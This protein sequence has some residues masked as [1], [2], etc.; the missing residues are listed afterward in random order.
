MPQ[1]LGPE[2]RSPLRDVPENIFEILQPSKRAFA[3]G[4][5]ITQ[6]KDFSSIGWWKTRLWMGKERLAPQSSECISRVF[7]G[8]KKQKSGE[9]KIM[10]EIPRWIVL[11]WRGWGHPTCAKLYSKSSR[12]TEK[13]EDQMSRGTNNQNGYVGCILG[14]SKHLKLYGK[15]EWS[16]DLG[17]FKELAHEFWWVLIQGT[18]NNLQIP[19]S[20][21]YWLE[22]KLI[23]GCTNSSWTLTML[24]S[25]LRGDGW[26]V[27]LKNHIK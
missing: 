8:L 27:V 22:N 3:T 2:I 6:Q 7:S 21:S 17:C 20:G 1:Q 16:P 15:L 9:S 5:N 26:H 23:A 11:S 19:R 24:C 25:C 13:N 18:M 4:F 10:V 14:C 12:W